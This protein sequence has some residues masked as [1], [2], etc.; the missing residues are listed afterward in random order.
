M[1]ICSIQRYREMK[2]IF[3]LFIKYQ[4]FPIFHSL[5]FLAIEY[6]AECRFTM[7]DICHD[8]YELNKKYSDQNKI[9]PTSPSVDDVGREHRRRS[10]R[11]M[12]SNRI[13][14]NHRLYNDQM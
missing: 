1:E 4:I 7:S 10:T 11:R 2:F 13:S 12:R 9:S 5:L 8:L 6:E 3:Y 14:S